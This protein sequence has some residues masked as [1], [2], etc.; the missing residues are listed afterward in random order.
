MSAVLLVLGHVKFPN[1]TLDAV[2]HW[3]AERTVS[4]SPATPT[5]LN[6][7]NFCFT[8]LYRL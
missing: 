3:T 7:L 4:L 1:L 2:G 6:K 5:C 8:K